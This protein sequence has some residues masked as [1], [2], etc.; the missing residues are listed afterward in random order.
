M[1]ADRKAL[2]G[3]ALALLLGCDPGM[4]VQGRVVKSAGNA[5]EKA[6]VADATVNVTCPYL[7]PDEGITTKTDANGAFTMTTVGGGFGDDC[8]LKVTPPGATAP[9]VTTIGAVKAPNEDR[10]SGM[11]QVEIA[12][13]EK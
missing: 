12:V 13:P 5:N 7:K 11:R 2:V 10:K 1:Q 8:K 4:S 6:A 9:V 3:I